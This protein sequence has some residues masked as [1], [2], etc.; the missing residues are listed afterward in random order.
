MSR[1]LRPAA[2]ARV[3]DTYL[4]DMGTHNLLSRDEEYE[5][6]RLALEGTE[7]EKAWAKEKM[8]NCNLRL[9]VSI[10]KQYSYRGIP[11]SDLIQE[12][13]IGLMRAVEK[14]EYHRGFKFSTYASWWIRQAV[15]RAIESQCRTIRVP[16]YKLEVLNRLNSTVR[17]LGRKL[18][19]EP[20]RTE[21]AEGMEMEIDEVDGLFRMMREPVSLDAPMGDEGDARVGDFIGDEQAEDP[22]ANLVREALNNKVGKALA[23]LDPREEKVLRLRFGL[24]DYETRSLEMIGREFSLT[25]ERIRQIEIRALAKLRHAKRQ[26]YL[27]DF[28]AAEA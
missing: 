27:A 22:T 23:T 7:Q 18:G 25:R 16:I 20:T 2:N 14:F 1:K 8:I 11:M 9:V 3:L 21:V 4:R 12:G 10:A 19:R 24:D 13:N 6:A 17:D 15:V 28:A 26:H 5:V